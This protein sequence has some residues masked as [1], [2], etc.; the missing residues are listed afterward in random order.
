MLVDAVHRQAVEHIERPHPFAV[1]LGEVVV[2]GHYV[3]AV[4]REGVEEHGEGGHEGLT[5]TRCHFGY[6]ALMQH[7]AAEELHVV[8]H[9]VPLCVVAAGN[10]VVLVD[11]LVALDAHKVLRGGEFAVE[12]GGG[13]G[14]FLVLREA[15]CRFLHD[16]EGIG[17][18][19]V[20]GFLEAFEHFLFEFVYLVEDDFAVFDRRVLNLGVEC[21]NLFL[22]VVGRRLYGLLQ[23]FRLGTQRIV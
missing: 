3:Y 19:G 17:Q 9:H 15:A 22:D 8:V 13:H 5:F 20:E 18:C 14:D 11:S 23:F 4:A 21:C 12:V 10:P 2:H 7:H 6:F 16:G 1:A